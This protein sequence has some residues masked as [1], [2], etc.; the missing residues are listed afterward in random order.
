MTYCTTRGAG[1]LAALPH[2]DGSEIYVQQ[3][4]YQLGSVITVRVRVP[5]GYG[6]TAV[7]LRFVQDAE[8]RTVRTALARDDE[9]D[10]WY[11]AELPLHNPVTSYRFA[12]VLPDD[13][14]WLNARGVHDRG[15]TDEND[16][17]ITTAAPAPEWLHHSVVYQVFPDRFARS[18]AADDRPTPE[19]AEPAAWDDEPVAHGA[20]TGKQLYGGDLDG[21]VEHLDHIADLGVTTV[22]LTPI[23]PGRSAHRYDA[24]TFD[25]VDPL[26]GGDEA[27]VRL[28][29]ALHARG[30]RIMGDITT[31]HTGE[32][33]EWF[34][35]ARTDESC[36]ERDFYYWI[37]GGPGY[38]SWLGHSSLPKLNFASP[39]LGPRLIDGPGSVIGKWLQA[40]WSLDGWRVDV[41]NMTGRYADN[42]HNE[43]V[44]RRL[45]ATLAAVNPDA[46]LISEH[47]H[48]ARGDLSGETWHGNMNY[49]AFS[50]PVWTWL[51]AP[52][53]GI[54]YM[55]VEGL[56]MPRRTG[57]QMVAEMR[58]FDAAVPWQVLLNQ[59]NM[60]GSHDTPRIRTVVGSREMQEVAAGLLFTYLGVPAMFAGD[61]LGLT[62]TTGE[63]ARVPMP[64]DRPERRD[65]VIHERYRTLARLRAEHR[66]LREGSLR[67]VLTEDDAVGYVRETADEALLVVVARAAWPGAELR[68]AV[69][70]GMAE[71]L[72]GTADLTVTEHD[73]ATGVVVPG[74][75]PTV[76]VWKLR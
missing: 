57:A 69:P 71:T 10:R 64:W 43:D 14:H 2:H 29:D 54:R 74:D 61:E 22:Y 35:R 46:A 25:E 32:G 7:L 26:L 1:A 75:G 48:D 8:P 19:W 37:D 41:A 60:L 34:H 56:A 36:A 62:G 33:H 30:M 31:N 38:A 70:S 16:F 67:W 20:R 15:V 3:G 21:V 27:L 13:V 53:N 47:F 42:D 59:W 50:N 68:L 40:P 9:H 17:R 73:G 66:A 18:A 76:G 24:S 39:E 72:Y 49:T 63:H 28:S 23:F 12:L 58:D 4:P 45:R 55:G 11:E 65:E 6:E 52:G 51:A 5:R 44:G